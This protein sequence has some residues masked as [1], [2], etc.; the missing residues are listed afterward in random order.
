[1][2][3]PRRMRILQVAS[4]D[5]WAGAEVQFFYLC[6]Q[7]QRA[8]ADVHVVLLNEG[9]LAQRLRS[10][11]IPTQVF[12]EN[13]MSIWQIGRQLHAFLQQLAPN[14]IHT[15][16][17]KENILISLV[18]AVSVR[19]P[20]VRTV[21]GGQE[22]LAPWWQLPTHLIHF[23]DVMCGIYL[24]QA[25]IA[26]SKKLGEDLAVSYGTSHVHVI[27][28]AIDVDYVEALAARAPVV[29]PV[30]ELSASRFNIAIVGRLVPVKRHDLLLQ[31]L[32]QLGDVGVDWHLYVIGDGPL[33]DGV[34]QQVVNAGL[35]ARVTF[36]GAVDPIYPLLKRM[37]L[38]VMPSDHEGLPMTLLES[39]ALGVPV[40]AHAV[41]G[42][43]AVTCNGELAYLIE[44]HDAA[45]YARVIRQVMLDD[46]GRRQT[47][48][49]ACAHV[50]AHYDVSQ[51]VGSFL[52]LYEQLQSQQ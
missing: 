52:Q 28:N 34:K 9:I 29:D 27:E 18:N 39:M 4:G 33:L 3:T 40:V 7:L 2:V 49:R 44:D 41:G 14:I 19:A 47:A 21:H 12:S 23:L 13:A 31:V 6:R 48:E 46:A 8:G 42:I 10:E 37:D 16:R 15:H 38:L 17:Y 25:V 35:Q 5:L 1:M 43:P 30:V 20:S 22:I 24:Q 32:Q 26:V 45:G 11:K 36:T 51:K 50:R